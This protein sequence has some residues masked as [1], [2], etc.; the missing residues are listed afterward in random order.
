MSAS[1]APERSRHRLLVGERQPRRR[2]RQQRRCPA[3]D[4]TDQE[5]IGG[6]GACL[7]DDAMGGG[8]A[9]PIGVGM[10]GF[11]DLDALSR[12]A[13]AVAGDDDAVE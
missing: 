2:Q 10:T 11:D 5:I 7:G 12:H 6:E 9:E 13:V 1:G 4:Q 8:L 3:R